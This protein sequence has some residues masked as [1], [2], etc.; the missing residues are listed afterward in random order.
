MIDR[1]YASSEYPGWLWWL[2]AVLVV[3][4]LVDQTRFLFTY[5]VIDTAMWFGDETWTMLTVRALARTGVA[6]VPEALGSS[7]AHSNGLI[8][9]SIWVSG[10]LYGLPALLFKSL[11]SPVAIGRCVTLTLSIATVLIVYRLS[12]RVGASSI[13]SMVGVLS[14]VI[15]NAFYFSSHSARLDMVTGLGVLAYLYLLAVMFERLETGLLTTRSFFVLTLLAA[16]SLSIYVHVP[17]L[18]ALPLLYA[19]WK[20]GTFGNGQKTVWAILGTL[21]GLCLMVALYW[22]TTSGTPQNGSLSLL[23]TGYNQYYNVA[24]SLPILHL[25][26]WR[27]Q[28]INTI[29]RFIQLWQVAWPLVLGLDLG[30]IF[31]A[32]RLTHPKQFFLVLTAWVIGSWMLAEGP[33]VFYNIH[34]LPVLA[35]ATAILLERPLTEFLHLRFASMHMTSFIIA[36][37]AIGFTVVTMY[38][39]EQR[40]H[41][42]Q[43]LTR[44]NDAAIQSLIHPVESLDKPPLILTDQ[45]ALNAIADRASAGYSVRLMTNHLLLFGGE[46]KPLSEILREKGVDYILLYATPHW[47]S[48]FCPIADSLYTLVGGRTGT[49]TDLGRTYDEPAWNEIDT[50]RLYKAK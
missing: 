47:R 7:L 9:G 35:V 44:A 31:G 20:F 17:T 40:G 16:C 32:R 26:A 41:I 18:I 46:D 13:A 5:P 12:R 15:S 11:A 36:I 21:T 43:Q 48:P 2:L 30:L 39:Q 10:L 1:P 33:A 3:V 8:N 50:L 45:A 19:L 34:A 4:L 22:L 49:L 6:C 24:N 38:S 28:K 23:G 29:D 14:F 37:V 42:G 27:V 25:F